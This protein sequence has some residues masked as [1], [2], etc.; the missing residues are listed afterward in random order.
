MGYSGMKR[1]K[2]EEIGGSDI[3]MYI[4][5]TSDIQPKDIRNS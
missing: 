4:Q 3:G 1:K 5:S 2:I